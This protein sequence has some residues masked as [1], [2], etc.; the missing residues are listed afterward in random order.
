MRKSSWKKKNQKA[1]MV[2]RDQKKKKYLKSTCNTKQ[3]KT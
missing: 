1:R 3:E 2:S